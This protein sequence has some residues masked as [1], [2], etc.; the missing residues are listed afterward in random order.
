MIIDHYSYKKCS[1]RKWAFNYEFLKLYFK[2][3]LDFSLLEKIVFCTLYTT[4]I[5]VTI[6]HEL[7]LD[8]QVKVNEKGNDE[9][10]VLFIW[11]KKNFLIIP[12]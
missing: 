12:I 11:W 5:K 8:E 7:I 3:Q 6:S 2:R 1:R 4:A 10:N 9:S